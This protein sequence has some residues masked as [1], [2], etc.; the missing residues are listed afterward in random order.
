M[1]QKTFLMEPK[2]FANKMLQSK[3]NFF[4]K[5]KEQK[6]FANENRVQ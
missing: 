6:M 4:T 2:L 3:Q 1:E 5:A